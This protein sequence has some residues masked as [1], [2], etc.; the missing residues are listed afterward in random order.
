MSEPKDA[1]VGREKCVPI[2]GV[3]GDV[4][5]KPRRLRVVAVRIANIDFWIL[6]LALA[7]VLIL[8]LPLLVALVV[9]CCKCS[10]SLDEIC[11]GEDEDCELLLF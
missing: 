9:C 11:M 4:I 2:V 7:F 3:R 8:L 5:V 10:C 6:A 1:P